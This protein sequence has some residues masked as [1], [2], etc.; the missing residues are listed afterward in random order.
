MKT[1]DQRLLKDRLEESGI[2]LSEDQFG[3]FQQYHD[4][5]LNWSKRTNLISRSDEARIVENHFLES[6]SV[7]TALDLKRGS[8]ILDIGS[9][10]GFPGI[11]VGITRKDLNIYL[12]ES[13]RLKT[14]FL[15]EVATELKTDNISI[16]QSRCESPEIKHKFASR[17]DYVFSRAVGNLDIVYGWVESLL[18]NDGYYIAWKGG[19]VDSEIREL[20]S[21]FKSIKIN[22]IEMDKSFVSAVKGRFFV[23]IKKADLI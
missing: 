11:P 17:F 5:L 4:L 7:L 13:K 9:G 12:L 10:G 22:I 6:L 21:K 23:I 18:K 14:L 20:E 16:V 3:K 8:T 19:D 15:R 2:N 1:F